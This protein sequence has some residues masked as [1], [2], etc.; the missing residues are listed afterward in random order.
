MGEK[1]E[2]EEKRG[3]GRR[4]LV[5]RKERK[6]ENRR[7]SVEEKEKERNR[8]CLHF[9]SITVSHLP[10]IRPFVLPLMRPFHPLARRSPRRRKQ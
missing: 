6:E 10:P 7:G 3:G 4:G 8:I 1:R 9:L 2:K 5:I